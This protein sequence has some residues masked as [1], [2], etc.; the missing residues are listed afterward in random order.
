MRRKN[1]LG[2][3]AQGA[4]S[5]FRQ[6]R[7]CKQTIHMREMPYAQWVAFD[8]PERVHDCKNVSEYNNKAGQ[9]GASKTKLRPLSPP[10]VNRSVEPELQASAAMPKGGP[11]SFVFGFLGT[12]LVTPVLV[13]LAVLKHRESWP[14]IVVAL[15]VLYLFL[16]R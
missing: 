10:R 8:A 3:K 9:R 6:C 11:L 15:V 1:W 7:N 16:R 12:L 14:W 4:E 5:Y 13:L 2:P